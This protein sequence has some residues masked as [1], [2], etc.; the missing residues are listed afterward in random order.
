MAPPSLDDV[1]EQIRLVIHDLYKIQASAH[2]F[3][4]PETSRALQ[5]HIKTLTN[6]LRVLIQTAT[7]LPT[8]IPPEIIAYVDEGR[9]PDIY[10]REF[11][12]LAQR[13]NQYLKGKSEA[14]KNFR[15]ALAREIMGAM[16][17]TKEEVE[18]VVQETGGR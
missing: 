1:E 17:D 5:D 6:H 16:P 2:G 11:V 3:Q 4:D 15:D 13:G 10:T 14:F 9:N 18:R 8:Q 12:E 7:P